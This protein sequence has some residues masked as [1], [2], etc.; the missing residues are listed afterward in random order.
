MLAPSGDGSNARLCKKIGF[1]EVITE[2]TK[3]DQLSSIVE[4]V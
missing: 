2:N 4:Q 3:S 1:N